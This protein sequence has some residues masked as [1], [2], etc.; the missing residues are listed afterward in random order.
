VFDA[1][2]GAVGALFWGELEMGGDSIF[3]KAD[4]FWFCAAGYF[5]CKVHGG[6]IEPS[7][8]EREL[9]LKTW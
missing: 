9:F 7:V 8:G 6:E 1:G 2:E 5:P 3:G 4:L